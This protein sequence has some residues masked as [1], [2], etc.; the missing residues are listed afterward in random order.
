MK[1]MRYQKKE[2][3]KTCRNVNDQIF[4]V[5]PVQVRVSAGDSIRC[6]NCVPVEKM[7]NLWK[8]K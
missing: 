3:E 5:L 1:M 7:F 8:K 6:L 2:K 4:R